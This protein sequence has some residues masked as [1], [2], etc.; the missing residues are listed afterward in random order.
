MLLVVPT[1]DIMLKSVF[2]P[3]VHI[4]NLGID[5]LEAGSFQLQSIYWQR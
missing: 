4:Q 3:K 1:S 5:W 2:D